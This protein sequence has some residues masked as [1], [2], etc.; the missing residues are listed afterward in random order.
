MLLKLH[1]YRLL[2]PTGNIIF[3]AEHKIHLVYSVVW[4]VLKSK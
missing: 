3:L 4:F 1:S 2:F